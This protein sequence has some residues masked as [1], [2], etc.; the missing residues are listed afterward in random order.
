[1][2]NEPLRLGFIGGALDS[3]VGNTHRIA[4]Q[5]D[6]RWQV[7][8]ACFSTKRDVNLATADAW[9]VPAERLHADWLTMLRAEHDRLDAVI[10]LTP[11]PSHTEIVIA[12]LELGIAVIC[13]KALCTSVDDALAIKR[14][15]EENSGYL[16]VIYNYTGYP[17]LREMQHRVSSGHIGQIQQVHVE[18]PQE[19]FL[20]LDQ[21]NNP[22]R[23]QSWRLKDGVIPT[24]SLDLGVHVENML[25]YLSG[26]AP[27]E[28]V[29]TSR[30]SGFFAD[31]LDNT[32]CLARY[33]GDIDCQ[34]WFSKS[35]LGH[36]NGLRARVFGERGSLE[37]RQTAAERL[38]A[39]D[40]KGATRTIERYSAELEVANEARY[41][42]FK[43][44]HPDGFFEAFSNY[45]ADLADSVQQYQATGNWHNPH[46]FGIDDAL[47]GLQ[48]LQAMQRSHETRAW[49]AIG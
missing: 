18:M 13:E 48:L 24:L 2:S 26:A 3:A 29:A 4:C 31:V 43:P 10:V 17:M 46:V 7:V 19:G 30:T 1:M 42:R 11:T 35:S 36:S 32:L 23:P 45:Y 39:Y 15:V 21:D 27:E 12:A 14:S 40:N 38:Y 49:Q 37:W 25:H 28:V 34:I 22:P 5:M 8:A 16:A 33:S 6:R 44:G 41:N 9:G 20:R 47:R